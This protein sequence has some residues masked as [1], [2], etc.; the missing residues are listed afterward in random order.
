MKNDQQEAAL[1]L[2]VMGVTGVGKTTLGMA[3]AGRFRLEFIDADDLHPKANVDKMRSGTPLNDTDRVPWLDLVGKQLLNAEN[4]VV[5]ACSALKRK[6]RDRILSA[7]PGTVFVHAAGDR[8]L[9]AERLNGRKGHYMP[10]SLLASQLATLEPLEADE[11][12]L[13][14]DIKGAPQDVV[15]DIYQRLLAPVAATPTAAPTTR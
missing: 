5:I 9:I 14:V 13:T 10:P 3:L 2:V 1:R 11:P 4:G 8:E 15:E 6:Y 7:A 12:G